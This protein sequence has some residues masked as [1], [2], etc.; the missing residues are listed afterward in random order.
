MDQKSLNKQLLALGPNNV[1]KRGY[2]IASD[3]SGKIIQK[4]K[5]LIVGEIF[6]LKMSDGSLKAEKISEIKK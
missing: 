4:S 3:E 1:L 2:S 6:S 5:E